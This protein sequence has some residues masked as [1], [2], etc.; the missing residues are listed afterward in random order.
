MIRI[1]FV[2]H[3]L[4]NGTK[5]SVL[6]L[7][8][9]KVLCSHSDKMVP[10]VQLFWLPSY[11]PKKCYQSICVHSVQCAVMLVVILLLPGTPC[12]RGTDP[13]VTGAQTRNVE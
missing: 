1:V 6:K 8:S 7:A 12:T 11:L 3:K 13:T 9:G 4:P 2:V 5:Q 10:R